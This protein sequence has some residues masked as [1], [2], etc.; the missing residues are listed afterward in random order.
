MTGVIQYSVVAIIMEDG[1]LDYG[2]HNCDG[3]E[4]DS[5][6]CMKCGS[7]IGA[8]MVND[9]KELAEWLIEYCKQD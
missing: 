2:N 5:Y 7:P 1:S 6:Q 8:D 3:G 9:E 4:V